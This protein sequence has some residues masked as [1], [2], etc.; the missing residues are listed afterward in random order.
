[1]T[2]STRNSRALPWWI[3]WRKR[4][5]P[6]AKSLRGPAIALYVV[7]EAADGYRAVY[8]L[9]ELDSAFTDRVIL[10]ADRRDGRPLSAREGPLQVIVPGEKKHARWVRQ[11]IRLRV[12]AADSIRL[13]D[14]ALFEVL[15]APAPGRNQE[16]GD[17]LP[18]AIRNAFFGAH[19]AERLR[20]IVEPAEQ[21]VSGPFNESAVGRTPIFQVAEQVPKLEDRAIRN[22]PVSEQLLDPL[23]GRPLP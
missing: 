9:A 11:V 16:L 2:A 22:P 18:M 15:D 14:H 4:A 10:L 20:Q 8:A 7:V 17:D 23:I 12:A 21:E 19:Q 1:M 6:P 5:F 3:S 13:V